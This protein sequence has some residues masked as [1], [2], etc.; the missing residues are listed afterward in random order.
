MASLCTKWWF[1]HEETSSSWRSRRRRRVFS[2]DSNPCLVQLF[3]WLSLTRAKALGSF[4]PGLDRRREELFPRMVPWIASSIWNYHFQTRFRAKIVRHK[5]K[6]LAPQWNRVQGRSSVSSR[7]SL[8]YAKITR[9][10]TLKRKHCGLNICKSDKLPLVSHGSTDSVQHLLHPTYPFNKT[11]SMTVVWIEL[12]SD[13]NQRIY[14]AVLERNRK[15]VTQNMHKFTLSLS[16]WSFQARPNFAFQLGLT[17]VLN[18][19]DIGGL[20]HFQLSARTNEWPVFLRASV[21]IGDRNPFPH[22][23]PRP[24]M[25]NFLPGSQWLI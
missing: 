6:S 25:S 12:C 9:S 11:S 18:C 4:C 19:T 15:I 23:T 2:N 7:H 14:S 10:I 22:F 17:R 16:K 21:R 20:G 13:E 3:I 1:L 5:K 24:N 8:I